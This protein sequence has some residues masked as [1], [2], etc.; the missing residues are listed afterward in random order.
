M[1]IQTLKTKELQDAGVDVKL[2]TSLNQKE[3]EIIIEKRLADAKI[4]PFKDGSLFYVDESGVIL[5][6]QIG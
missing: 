5:F 6:V 4:R 2:P 3:Q 1:G